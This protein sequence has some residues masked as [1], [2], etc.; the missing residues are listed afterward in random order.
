MVLLKI[1]EGKS[2]VENAADLR[3]CLED[4]PQPMLLSKPYPEAVNA[5]SLTGFRKPK[6]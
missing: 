5:I 3:A 2:A 4:E 6:P 1:E